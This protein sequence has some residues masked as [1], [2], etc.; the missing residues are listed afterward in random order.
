MA[1]DGRYFIVEVQRQNQ[2][3]FKKRSLLY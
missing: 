3:H 1:S 2:Y